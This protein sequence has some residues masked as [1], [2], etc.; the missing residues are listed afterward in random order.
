MGGYGRCMAS[1]FPIRCG[2][3]S[4]CIGTRWCDAR[5]IVVDQAKTMLPAVNDH[6]DARWVADDF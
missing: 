4:P 6:F 3:L 1:S 2:W 5:P